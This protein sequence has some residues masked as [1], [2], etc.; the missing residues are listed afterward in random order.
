MVTSAKSLRWRGALL[1]IGIPTL[2]CVSTATAQ[3][4]TQGYLSDQ[5]LQNGMIVRLKSGDAKKVEALK[6]DNLED[7]FGITVAS[8]DTPV[9]VSDPTQNQ[10]FVATQGKY[11]VLVSNQNGPIKSGDYITISALDGVGMKSDRTQ[12]MVLGK[13][14]SGFNGA[15]DRDSVTT[16]VLGDGSKQEVS[17]KRIAVDIKVARNPIYSGDTVAGVPG[18]LSKTATL[19]ATHPISAVRIYA[20]LAILLV[21]LSVGGAIIYSGVHTGI[22]SVGRNPLAK[23]SIMRGLFSVTLMALIVVTIGIIAVYLLL[24]I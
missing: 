24:R 17:L 11:Q 21:A 4:I 10:V 8:T 13:A 19:V 22:H 12:E 5:Q 9:S 7:M 14:L 6:L 16:L 15:A 2:L 23:K 1:L 20:C 18:F 3:N